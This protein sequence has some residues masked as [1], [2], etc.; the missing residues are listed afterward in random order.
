[1]SATPSRSRDTATVSDMDLTVPSQLRGDA[2]LALMV[3]N[4]ARV[5]AASG[6]TMEVCNPATGEV[7]DTVP[8]ADADDTR[9]AIEAA[10]AAFPEWSKTP[11]HKR[12]QILMRAAARVREEL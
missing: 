9:R 12:A 8:K 7:V 4:G 3:I 5:G 2:H 10:A 6:A 11:P 1:M